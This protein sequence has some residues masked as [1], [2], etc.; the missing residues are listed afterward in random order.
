MIDEKRLQQFLGKI[1]GDFG[2]AMSVPLVR[3]GIRLGLTR[4]WTG[5]DQ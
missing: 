3:V 1:V 5:P 2:A 4:H